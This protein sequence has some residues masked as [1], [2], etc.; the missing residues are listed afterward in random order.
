MAFVFL[1]TFIPN[2]T[3]F[4]F[5]DSITCKHDCTKKNSVSI[6]WHNGHNEKTNT[7]LLTNNRSIKQSTMHWWVVS[8]A[9]Q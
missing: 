8:K 4:A 2:H 6:G 9:H 3:V 5:A 1:V 7:Y